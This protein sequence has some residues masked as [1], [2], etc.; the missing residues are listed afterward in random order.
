MDS[1]K[2]IVA[3]SLKVEKKV[4][5]ESFIVVVS[6]EEVFETDFQLK[7]HLLERE[8]ETFMDPD[9]APPFHVGTNPQTSPHPSILGCCSAVIAAQ[10]GSTGGF[11]FL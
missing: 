2:N 6:F 8:R 10:G 4:C 5:S 11:C 9:F 3:N 7:K 1:L